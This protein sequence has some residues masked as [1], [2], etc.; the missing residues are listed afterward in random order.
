MNKNNN[1]QQRNEGTEPKLHRI[2]NCRTEIQEQQAKHEQLKKKE[3][4]REK[5]S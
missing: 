1:E 4:R 5:C 3:G 2:E